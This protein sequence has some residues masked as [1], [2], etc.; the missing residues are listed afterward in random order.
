[1]ERLPILVVVALTSVGIYLIGAKRLGLPPSG[2][3]KAV[4]KM[5]EGV[6]MTL[7]LFAVNLAAGA[8]TILAAGMVTGEFSLYLITHEAD[9]W[10]VLS[11]VQALTFQWWREASR[12]CSGSGSA[13]AGRGG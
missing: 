2:F 13:E 10:L 7:V 5:L 12:R 6:G 11:L 1:M 8:F 9:K 3:R 4:G